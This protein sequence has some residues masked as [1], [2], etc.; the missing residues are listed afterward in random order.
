P[1]S[2]PVLARVGPTS[3]RSPLS[4]PEQDDRGTSQ[5]SIRHHTAVDRTDACNDPD[6]GSVGVN[7]PHPRH[8]CL[9]TS[10]SGTSDLSHSLLGE[11]TGPF[12]GGRAARWGDGRVALGAAHF[13]RVVSIPRIDLVTGAGA[14]AAPNEGADRAAAEPSLP[15]G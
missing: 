8:A 14:G 9:L 11:E 6:L 12:G 10:R 15:G 1:Y 5:T 2:L 4:R 13:D 7:V 3:M